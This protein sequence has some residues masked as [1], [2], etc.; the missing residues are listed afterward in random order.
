VEELLSTNPRDRRR[1]CITR[2]DATGENPGSYLAFCGESLVRGAG[3][4][5][6]RSIARGAEDQHKYLQEL[7]KR[8]AESRKPLLDALWIVDV[9]LQKTGQPAHRVRDI[10]D[11]A[12]LHEIRN[13]EKCLAAGFEHVFLLAPDKDA[14]GRVRNRAAAVLTPSQMK[15]VRFVLRAGFR[16]GFRPGNANGSAPI[17]T[18]M[19]TNFSLRKRLRSMLRIDVKTI[20]NYVQRGLIPYVRFQSNLRFVKSEVRG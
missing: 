2:K 10:R 11:H 4:A 15:K 1:A 18:M 6:Q 19:P 3:R 16:V 13:T 9:V 17:R 8:W 7:I 12:Y 14:L 5:A 20:Y